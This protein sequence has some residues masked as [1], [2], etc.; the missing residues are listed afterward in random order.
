MFRADDQACA[1]D[2]ILKNGS[3]GTS[4]SAVVASHMPLTKFFPRFQDNF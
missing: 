1:F 4:S 3:N 2:L